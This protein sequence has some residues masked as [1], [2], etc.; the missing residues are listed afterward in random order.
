[1]ASG[2]VDAAAL[3][4]SLCVCIVRQHTHDCSGTCFPVTPPL[5]LE[6]LGVISPG[7]SSGVHPPTFF[8]NIVPT[9]G[10]SSHPGGFP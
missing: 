1:M 5:P 9:A 6:H 8:V 10:G 7:F 3:L 2:V 4:T